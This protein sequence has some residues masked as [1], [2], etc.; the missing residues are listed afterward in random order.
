MIQSSSSL[1][2]APVIVPAFPAASATSLSGQPPLAADTQP[3]P[4]TEPEGA[5]DAT[6]V[7]HYAESPFEQ[8]ELNFEDALMLKQAKQ[9]VLQELQTFAK[10]NPEA[11]DASMRQILGDKLSSQQLS[12]LR[13]KAE[14]GEFPLPQNIRFVSDETLQGNKAAYSPENGGTVYLSESLKENRAALA[15]ALSEEIGHHLDAQAGGPD[16]PGDEGQIFAQALHQKGPLS[17]E[18][19]E[20]A[21]AIMTK[22]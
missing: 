11:F 7:Q 9:S 10:T 19:L 13:Q 20:M 8:G 18:D 4:G 6:G 22:A 5:P 14:N 12:A 1:H 15:Y 17:A 2:G 3:T 16:T 21:R